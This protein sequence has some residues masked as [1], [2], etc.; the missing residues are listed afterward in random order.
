MG[1]HR[2]V[3]LVLHIASSPGSIGSR[4]IHES[5]RKLIQIF[6]SAV[7]RLTG[8]S[9][10]HDFGFCVFG[11]HHL[12]F[13]LEALVTR[14]NP[15]KIPSWRVAGCAS[16]R[17]LEVLLARLDV[18][19]LEIGDI[20]PLAPSFFR[21]RF[22]LLGMDK[23]HETGNLPIRKFKAGHA[24]LRTTIAHDCAYLVTASIGGHQFGPRKVRPGLSAAS[25]AAMTK[26]AV[27]PEERVPALDQSRR[28]CLA[29]NCAALLDC[30]S[31][32]WAGSWCLCCGNGETHEERN[33]L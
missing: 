3:D 27:A 6:Q 17:T 18:S 2:R 4:S 10:Y 9:C 16:A 7:D 30:A 19:G 29:S 22:V 32:W 1:I 12:L 33:Q 8:A 14:C 21:G 15:G 5:H 28:I 26:R 31:N 24:L 11:I 23:G 20:Y 13:E 25:V